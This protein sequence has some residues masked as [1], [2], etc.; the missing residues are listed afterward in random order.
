MASEVR[1]RP[2]DQDEVTRYIASSRES[3][4]RSRVE[5]G[6]RPEV[7]ERVAERQH[8]DLFPGGRPARRHQLFVVEADGQQV[9]VVWVGPHPNRP[10][11]E[12][13]AWLYDIEIADGHRGRGHGRAALAM[14]EDHLTAAGVTDVG[15]NV[16]GSNETARRLYRSAGWRELSVTMTKQL[17]APGSAETERRE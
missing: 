9:G 10:E 11:D 6:E 15:L 8:G 3:Y 16:F 13:T 17:A 12:G 5:A 7:A 4:V 2:M 1:L 14:I